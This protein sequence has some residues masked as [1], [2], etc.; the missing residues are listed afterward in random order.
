MSPTTPKHW[1]FI[2]SLTAVAPALLLVLG[3]A[4]IAA[5][6]LA[7]GARGEP[8][9]PAPGFER[10]SYALALPDEPDVVAAWII[11]PDERVPITDTA[12]APWRS[13]VQLVMF[14]QFT[15]VVGTCSGSMV[16]DTTV[17]TAA[18]CVWD[19]SFGPYHSI[20]AIP[21]S[22]GLDWPLGTG[23]TF[24]TNVT[25]PQG[26]IDTAGLPMPPRVEYD[27]ALVHLSDTDW[28]TATRPHMFV[29]APT[30][31]YLQS[32]DIILASAGFPGDQHA[33][34]MWLA[35][36]FVTGFTAVTMVT[37]MDT[38][39]GQS[40][41]PTWIVDVISDTVATAGVISYQQLEF[42]WH[43]VAVRF[44]PTHLDAL[45]HW[46]SL[47]G[48]TIQFIVPSD[49]QPS[50]PTSTPTP[51]SVS[52]ATPTPSP[53]PPVEVTHDAAHRV[54]VPALMRDTADAAPP[55]TATPTPAPQA[56]P[57]PAATATP[58]ASPSP[59]FTPSPTP[60][61]TWTPTSTPTPLPQFP[62]PTPTSTM[63]AGGGLTI[64]A[65]DGQA[66]LLA[67]DGTY[68]GVV[69]SNRFAADSICN[70]FG[71][72][73]SQFSSTSVRNQFSLYGSPFSLTSAYNQFTV[74][75]PVIVYLDSVVG[76]LTKNQF[77]PGA[78]DPDFLF[79]AYNCVY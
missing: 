27:F 64:W 38:V 77:L 14:D 79:A 23:F 68:L 73:G 45:D 51:T 44:T 69:S 74:T 25:V 35:A 9:A 56:T 62:S 54:V 36:G 20:L 5:S 18:H 1:S 12:E 22:D 53:T 32:P 26:W 15:N 50:P 29:G 63:P 17:L 61:P 24:G 67:S 2:P 39:S 71:N 4:G 30:D 11:G 48:C 43:N 76:Y 59:S 7:Q 70:Q 49:P 33:G 47:A 60:T 75:P 16:D 28:T 37:D 52:A 78:V 42:P 57:T 55:P 72:Y 66:Y 8:A 31:E 3:V 6:A 58:T 10:M 40:G 21:G 19:D 46:C 13:V 65:I 41:S 34:T